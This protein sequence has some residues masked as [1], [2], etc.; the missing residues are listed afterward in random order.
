VTPLLLDRS[1]VLLSSSATPA[2]TTSPPSL[3]H[4]VAVGG[5]LLSGCPPTG[6]SVIKVPPLP[7]GA[8]WKLASVNFPTMLSLAMSVPSL[9]SQ[10]P[11]IARMNSRLDR[12]LLSGVKRTSF[13]AFN[14]CSHKS[15]N[16]RPK[17]TV[18][19]T[20]KVSTFVDLKS[21]SECL[22]SL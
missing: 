15:V 11:L 3:D 21:F 19:G 8:A 2:R 18:F 9:T 13:E 16:F 22:P 10:L 20:E 6:G 1:I 4:A 17:R 12:C 14:F 5:A 7:S